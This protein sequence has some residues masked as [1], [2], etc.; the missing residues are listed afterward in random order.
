MN[1]IL[2]FLSFCDVY[3]VLTVNQIVGPDDGPL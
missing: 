2:S 3:I 1:E